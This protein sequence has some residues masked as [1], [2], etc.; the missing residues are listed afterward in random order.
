MSI[1]DSS[2]RVYKRDIVDNAVC[3]RRFH[4]AYEQGGK[5]LPE[6][7]VACP[8]CGVIVYEAQNHPVVIL[9]REENLIKSPDGTYPVIYQCQFPGI[10]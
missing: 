2:N 10:K 3:K 5:S 6:V 4:L 9:S 8:H 7:K 1:E